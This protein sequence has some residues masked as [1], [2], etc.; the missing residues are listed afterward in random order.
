[1]YIYI[2][3]VYI[4]TYNIYIYT[5]SIYIYIQYI[6][7]HRYIMVYIHMCVHNYM[8]HVYAIGVRISGGENHADRPKK[9]S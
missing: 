5:Y 7:I 1:M 2:H 6:Y 8:N 9:V 3:T 4:Y